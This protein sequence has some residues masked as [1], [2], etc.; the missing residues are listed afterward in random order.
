MKIKSISFIFIFLFLLAA[1]DQDQDVP[2]Y[3][4]GQVELGGNGCLESTASLNEEGTGVL[5]DFN[6]FN[7]Q[8]GGLYTHL[9]RK[10][11]NLAVPLD[12]PAGYQ[13]ALVPGEMTGSAD[14]KSKT[15]LKVSLSTFIAGNKG[16]T[17]KLT[18]DDSTLESFSLGGTQGLKMI[19]FSKCEESIILRVNMSLFLK[20]KNKE[21][22]SFSKIVSET[23]RGSSQAIDFL[24]LFGTAERTHG[25][26][27]RQRSPAANYCLVSPSFLFR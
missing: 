14:I 22:Q 9:E 10:S 13:V 4:L 19:E 21:D 11:C 2:E 5:L 23:R 12:V 16:T 26:A 15:T 18:I 25:K 20:S 8:A 6:N 7:V 24:D 1:C 17:N 3:Q 27:N